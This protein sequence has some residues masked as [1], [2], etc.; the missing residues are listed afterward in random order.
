MIL[1]SFAILP[2]LCLNS[3]QTDRETRENVSFKMDRF[4]IGEIGPP[5]A[6]GYLSVAFAKRSQ[7]INKYGD[8]ISL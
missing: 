6:A 4:V 5:I 2:R 7:V 3:E 1:V 8:I